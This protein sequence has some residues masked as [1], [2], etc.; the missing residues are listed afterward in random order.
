MGKMK[1]ILAIVLTLAMVMAMGMTSFAGN[2]VK[3]TADD[4]KEA[5]V[6]NVE[7]GATMTAYQLIDASYDDN[8]FTGYVWAGGMTNA[9]QKVTDASAAITS[10]LV[11]E[12]AKDTAGLTKIDNFVSGVTKLPVGTWMILVTPPANDAAKVYNPM[13]VSVYYALDNTSGDSDMVSGS[14]SAN[15]DWTINATTVYAKSSE[16]SV[17]KSVN[18]NE[19]EVANDELT[20]TITGT[21]PSYSNEY[22]AVVYKL[23]DSIK[24][25]LEY[26][27]DNNG[28][29]IAPVVK[30][31]GTVVDAAKYTYTSTAD[32]FEIAFNSEYI[33]GLAGKTDAERA[34]EIT[35]VA[36]LTAEAIEKSGENQ[37]VLKYSNKPDEIATK[38]DT[39]YVATFAI[40]GVLKKVGEKDD[41][42]GLAGAEFTLYRENENG[43][44][45]DVFATMTTGKD[46][47]IKFQGLDSDRTYYLKETNAP[48][49]YSV[50]E[51][52][53]TITF[54]NI[55]RDNAGKVTNYDVFVDGKKVSTISY[56]NASTEFGDTIENTKLSSLPS[57][58]GIGTTIFTIGGCV[59]MIAAA[60]LFFASRKKK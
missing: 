47:N 2:G 16:V 21:I 36:K 27:K 37:V 46:F 31:G 5:T 11:T 28:A 59:I 55:E 12:K 15:D 13:V 39:E 1:K 53:Y 52:I 43:K 25:G 22:T 51:T 32:N 42:N 41:K 14:V 17:I 38:D 26:K 23:K 45:S 48:S 56:G 57:T 58:G 20:Y 44:L 24:S 54:D 3:P 40:D 30:V 60:G 6:D 33:L 49:G 7:T 29:V 18:D 19:A 9:G 10:E 35:Y 34:V 8:G 50:N 4:A